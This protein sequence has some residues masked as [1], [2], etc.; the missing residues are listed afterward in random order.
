[1]EPTL[2]D[3][4]WLIYKPL[5]FIQYNQLNS[6]SIILLKHPKEPNKIIIKRIFSE[7]SYGIDVRGDNPLSSTDSRQFGLI[8]KESI[9]GLLDIII[10]SQ[11]NT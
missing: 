4:D 10:C 7:K 8:Q 3:G 9:I 5:K 11:S 6:G 2:R 1:M